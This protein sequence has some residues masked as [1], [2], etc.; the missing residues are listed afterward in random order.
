MRLLRVQW[1][2][3]IEPDS[4][5]RWMFTLQLN[6]N[7]NLTN[8]FLL[9]K[10]DFTA[11][12]IHLLSSVWAYLIEFIVIFVERNKLNQEQKHT[13]CTPFQLLF[14]LCSPLIISSSNYQPHFF[15]VFLCDVDLP[16]F[17][18]RTLFFVFCFERATR[19]RCLAIYKIKNCRIT[20]AT[21]YHPWV[22]HTLIECTTH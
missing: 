18:T 3:S 12:F 5:K 11:V 1:N 15:I 7:E 21:I 16:P 6:V 4:C 19:D 2:M 10:Y 20:N 22:T 9:H 8:S 17:F 13:D 14:S